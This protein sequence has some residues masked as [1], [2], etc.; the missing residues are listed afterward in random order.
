MDIDAAI[1]PPVFARTAYRAMDRHFLGDTYTLF[2][3]RYAELVADG[4]L[5]T[6]EKLFT[7]QFVTLRQWMAVLEI[8]LECWKED[9]P[10][11]LMNETGIESL[12]VGAAYMCLAPDMRSVL[13]GFSMHYPLIDTNLEV[14]LTSS[15]G[16]IE[17]SV[18]YYSLQGW[19]GACFVASAATLLNKAL[20]SVS[21]L[22]RGD[23]LHY[24]M[25]CN[26]PSSGHL[27]EEH[28][29]CPVAWE[30]RSDKR[31]GV[32]CFIPDHVLDRQNPCYDSALYNYMS[33]FL[34]ERTANMA[35]IRESNTT[36]ASMTRLRLSSAISVPSQQQMADGYGISTRALQQHLKDE[37]VSWQSLVDD[38]TIKRSKMLLS[39]GSSVDF[40]A[41]SL[42]MSPSNFRRKFKR[43]TGDSPG[44]Y[45]TD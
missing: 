15:R 3:D 32:R 36:W 27:Y 21:G 44:S 10:V 22:R 41:G 2:I 19:V 26:K 35:E 1:H 33:T 17:A 14:L 11:L 40:V 31:L 7:A 5:P 38:E 30:P 37:G 6:K 4:T 43:V 29:G 13:S 18:L 25:L 23:G 16:G 42:G 24:T 8:G 39:G 20:V 12:G 45:S 34:W 9:F 28:L